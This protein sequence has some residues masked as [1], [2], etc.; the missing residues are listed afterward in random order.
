MRNKFMSLIVAVIAVGF[1]CQASAQNVQKRIEHQEKRIS[2]GV[3]SH[4]LSHREAA[5][6]RA[7][8]GRIRKS[9]EVDR[10]HHHGRLTKLERHNLNR[11]LNENSK[12]IF[13]EKHERAKKA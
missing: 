6:L 5:K 11:R 13:R 10:K 7:A 3:R 2:Q 8:D 4:K 12:S 1:A 9:A